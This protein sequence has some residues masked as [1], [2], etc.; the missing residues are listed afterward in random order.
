[1][2]LPFI[3]ELLVS[4]ILQV[5]DTRATK[6][7]DKESTPQGN[8]RLD[9]IGNNERRTYSTC[10]HLASEALFNNRRPIP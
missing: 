2:L 4:W 8:A 5:A 10:S 1:M 7:W 3:S 6:M 9:F